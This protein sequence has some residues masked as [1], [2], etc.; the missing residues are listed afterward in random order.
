MSGTLE[1]GLRDRMVLESLRKNIVDHL[2]SL[3]WSDP[4]RYHDAIDYV[5]GFPEINDDVSLNTIA[6]SADRSSGFD[7]EMGSLAEEHGLSYFVDMFMEGDAVGWHI[8]GDVYAFLKK[9]RKL[10]V[11]DFAQVTDPIDF[12]VDVEEVERT[13]PTR[14]T[15]AYQKHWFTVA[16]LVSDTRDN[17]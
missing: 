14:V 6:F 17:D 11:W 15:Q 12:Y 10:P 5:D 13:K 1:G 16:F 4:N 2:D 7:L 3:G 9:N 8:S